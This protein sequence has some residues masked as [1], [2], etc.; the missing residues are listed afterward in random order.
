MWDVSHPLHHLP[1]HLPYLPPSIHRPS[2]P[3]ASPLPLCWLYQTCPHSLPTGTTYSVS[4]A[5]PKNSFQKWLELQSSSSSSSPR[6]EICH[7]QFR[8]HKQIK[9]ERQRRN[10]FKNLFS[11][12]LLTAKSLLAQ[13][14][15]KFPIWFSSFQ[16]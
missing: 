1:V 9:V 4:I 12:S 13:T 2:H 5:Q 11:Y 10:V 8:R 16:F 15:T 14:K 6:C 3:P 7:F